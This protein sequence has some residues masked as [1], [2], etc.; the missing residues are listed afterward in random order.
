MT[1]KFAVIKDSVR[2]ARGWLKNPLRAGA[3]CQTS[4]TF[5]KRIC[6]LVD[7]SSEHIVELGAGLGNITSELVARIQNNYCSDDFD[8]SMQKRCDNGFDND[9][10]KVLRNFDDSSMKC[11]FNCVEIDEQFYQYLKLKFPNTNIIK[12]SAENLEML[13]PKLVGKVGCIVSLIPMV[14][15]KPVV[16]QRIL[17][18]CM[19]MLKP[20]GYLLQGSYYWR[21]ITTNDSVK[22]SHMDFVWWN[23]PPIHIYKYE[24]L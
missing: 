14:S 22:I 21:P 6:D 24:N 3:F 8:S 20:G 12:G 11:N 2:F 1:T 13:M 17:R 9:D 10:G 15:L 23:V 16:R 5:T 19:A 4:K 18:S 7:F